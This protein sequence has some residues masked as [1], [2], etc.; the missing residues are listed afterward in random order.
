MTTVTAFGEM[1]DEPMDEVTL[2]TLNG[3]PLLPM[4]IIEIIMGYFVAFGPAS[5]YTALLIYP[6]NVSWSTT[7]ALA[8]WSKR[9]DVIRI[10]SA[11]M[12]ERFMAHRENS[13]VFS[14]VNTVRLERLKDDVKRSYPLSDLLYAN[15]VFINYKNDDILIRSNG[16]FSDLQVVSTSGLYRNLSNDCIKSLTV[17][18]GSSGGKLYHALEALEE[19]SLL[20]AGPLSFKYCLKSTRLHSIF[21]FANEDRPDQKSTFGQVIQN[22]SLPIPAWID[23]AM[24][25]VRR[26]IEKL[27]FVHISPYESA[28]ASDCSISRRIRVGYAAEKPVYA[29]GKDRKGSVPGTDI[30]AVQASYYTFLCPSSL[31]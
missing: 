15:P 14:N 10:S 13:T 19:L 22:H 5:A 16:Y 9:V 18:E 31:R 3:L 17:L 25:P 1:V 26:S 29:V 6:G 4:E 20:N 30:W 21:F 28:Y 27:Y 23:N 24:Y 11:Q 7:D 8:D 12:C 2:R